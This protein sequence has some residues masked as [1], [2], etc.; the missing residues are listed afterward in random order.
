MIEVTW[1]RML[2]G[3]NAADTDVSTGLAEVPV[4]TARHCRYRAFGLV[5]GEPS[6]LPYGPA[7]SLHAS[8]GVLVLPD[9]LKTST[10]APAGTL[11]RQP[12]TPHVDTKRASFTSDS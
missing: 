10:F 5:I 11:A 12:S 7:Q 9:R 4:R 3:R 8:S 6:A 1:G 2:R